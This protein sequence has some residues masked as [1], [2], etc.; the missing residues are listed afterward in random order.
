MPV[1]F[2][3]KKKEDW[4]HKEV[5]IPFF[6]ISDRWEVL[7]VSFLSVFG[8]ALPLLCVSI[9]F[10]LLQGQPIFTRCQIQ[11]L[12]PM[13]ALMWMLFG[14]IFTLIGI[15]I[16][17]VVSYRTTGKKSIGVG[18]FF[19]AWF[20]VVFWFS[21]FFVLYILFFGGVRPTCPV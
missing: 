3:N 9:V 7:K 1:V 21:M 6:K 14:W 8:P 10:S 5:S 12:V 19:A 17:S 15:S 16:F 11:M 20:G 18:N 4:L 13:F 2:E